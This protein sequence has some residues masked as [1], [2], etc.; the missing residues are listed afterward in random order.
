MAHI[1]YLWYWP[2]I[3][4]E[5]AHKIDTYRIYA[6]MPLID[7]HADVSTSTPRGTLIFSHIRRLRIFW[8]SNFKFQY[9]GFFQKNEYF[10]GYEDFVD[11]FG[12]HPN[13]GLVLGSFLYILES[14]K[15]HGTELGYFLVAIFQIFLGVLDIPDIFFLGER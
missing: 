12:G 15:G 5:P 10:L 3:I 14:F 8:G 4:T 7:V 11:I 1:V 2:N 9:F 13:I 6:K